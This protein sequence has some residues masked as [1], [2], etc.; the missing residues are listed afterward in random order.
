MELDKA[1]GFAVVLGWDDLKKVSDAC[2]ARVEYRS[3]VGTTVDYLSIWWVDAEG[4]QNRV[5]EYWTSTSSA[6]PSGIC[7][8]NKFQSLQLG[9]ALDFILM[10]QGQFT[11]SAGACRDGLA[12]IYPPTGDEHTEA[13]TWMK[14]VHGAPTNI[15]R[16]ADKRVATLQPGFLSHPQVK[17][18]G[19]PRLARAGAEAS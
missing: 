12:L 5:C 9:L 4:H 8:N 14:G 7:F 11:R 17:T 3:A 18:C 2:S 16:S 10:N 6:H 19:Y 15:S 13:A 1:L